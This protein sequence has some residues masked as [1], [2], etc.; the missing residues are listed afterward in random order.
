MISSCI[1]FCSG[2]RFS[3]IRCLSFYVRVLYATVVCTH[4]FQ[5]LHSK[6]NKLTPDSNQLF[7][8]MQKYYKWINF[9]LI[10]STPQVTRSSFD[11]HD[12]QPVLYC[13]LYKC[14]YVIIKLVNA[15]LCA[16]SLA[17]GVCDSQLYL[18]L[19]RGTVFKN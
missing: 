6:K 4:V 11:S 17:G 18:V 13:A 3:K 15:L 14:L 8:Q 5:V 10:T 1:W 16:V 2:K 9:L 19:V 12:G 7:N